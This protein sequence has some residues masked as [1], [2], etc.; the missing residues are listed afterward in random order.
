MHASAIMCIVLLVCVPWGALAGEIASWAG[1]LDS[2]KLDTTLAPNREVLV[3]KAREAVELPIV[4]RAMTLAEVGENRTWLDGR[5]AALEDEIRETFAL[6]MS[7]FA[8]CNT[9]AGELPLL[10][11]VY[12]LTGEGVFRGKV[13]AQLE[14]MALWTPLQRHGWTL[15]HPGARLAEGGDGNWLATGC[16]VRAIA[17]AL[18]LMPAEAI[19]GGLLARL[20]AL[21]EGEIAGVVDDW[22]SKRPWFV[23]SN[24]AITNQWVL[25]TEGL[26]RACLVL[27]VDE[28]RDAYELGVGNL[29]QALDA[30]GAHG[31]FEEGF[32]YASF[33]VTSMLHAA[34]AMAA[35]GDR[36]AVDH[37]F[38][39]NFPTWLV[40]HFQPADMIVNCFDAGKAR[41]GAEGARPLLA[42]LAVCTGSPV[43][44]WALAYQVDGAP[45]DLPGLASRALP[46]VAFEEAPPLFAAYERAARVN[47]R[48]SWRSHGSG[49]WVRGGHPLDQH[50]HCDRGHVNYISHGRP[51]L[52]EAGTP[53]YSHPLMG[54]HF[55]SGLGHNVLQLGTRE[56]RAV[57]AGETLVLEGWQERGVVA[58]ITVHTLDVDGGD[59]SLE[60]ASG[61]DGLSKWRRGVS[62]D[63]GRVKVRDIVEL[64]EGRTE[65]VL[66]RWHLGTNA[67]VSI[68]GEGTC[69][70]V[71][72][73]EAM[74]AIDASAP[75][76]VSQTRLPD[77]TVNE[78]ADKAGPDAMHTCLV[79]QS[80]EPVAALRLTTDVTGIWMIDPAS[81]AS[82]VHERRIS[83]P[84]MQE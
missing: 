17:D 54:S 15:Y 1:M 34:R 66:F 71:K 81:P 80:A 6:A 57:D 45:D 8:A 27:G 2:V 40:H 58:P 42:M 9:L 24:N 50:D 30:H 31:E 38:L 22:K 37:P 72:W 18:D 19:P 21:L 48:D 5:A 77:N 84:V 79:V 41:G 63:L 68:S 82:E 33:T 69:W 60:V 75:L 67:Q 49:V 64:V 73:P 76:A 12:R 28:H 32:G 26:V 36:R 7:D 20:H 43:A 78:A 39:K 53:S 11:A 10:S 16:G 44:R 51:I 65:I 35:A 83:V 55:S 56:A 23:R 29:L 47:W 3:A 25:P 62:W 52:I 14:E 70:K 74:V 46:A 4:K 61:Y 13:C 59:V